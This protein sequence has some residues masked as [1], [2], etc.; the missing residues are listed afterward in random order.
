M[1]NTLNKINFA[2]T[3]GFKLFFIY[4]L[5]ENYFI[6]MDRVCTSYIYQLADVK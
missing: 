1:K 3:I 6:I 4:K 5:A 2:Q